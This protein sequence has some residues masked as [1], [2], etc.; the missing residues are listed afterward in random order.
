MKIKIN[1]FDDKKKRDFF[2]YILFSC[3][4]ECLRQNIS[5]S[6]IYFPIYKALNIFMRSILLMKIY[7]YRKKAL[8][9]SLADKSSRQKVQSMG[10]SHLKLKGEVFFLGN[11]FVWLHFTIL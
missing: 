8:S 9:V 5:Y 1:I 4:V 2:I 11:F 10:K 3:I 7:I 6:L